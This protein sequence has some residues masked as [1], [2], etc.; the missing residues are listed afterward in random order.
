MTLDTLFYYPAISICPLLLPEECSPPTH[1][2]RE[3]WPS[4]DTITPYRVWTGDSHSNLEVRK[5]GPHSSL[6]HTLASSKPFFLQCPLFRLTASDY[7]LWDK[8][9][10]SALTTATTPYAFKAMLVASLPSISRSPRTWSG[11]GVAITRSC[12]CCEVLDPQNFL[13]WLQV[14]ILVPSQLNSQCLYQPVHLSPSGC[15]GW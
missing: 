1:L 11:F 15:L 2:H 8:V 5:Q 10:L 14:F 12:S 6:S 4:P 3:I 7:S 13:V 9:F